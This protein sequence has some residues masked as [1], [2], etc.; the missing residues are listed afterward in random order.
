MANEI[1][2]KLDTAAA[3]TQTLAS[4]PTG[5]AVQTTMITNTNQRPGALIYYRLRS[6]GTGP[7]AGSVYELFLLRSDGTVSDDNAGASD[8]AITIENAPLLGT[9]ILTNTANKYF[10]GVFDTAPLGPLGSSWGIAVRNSSGQTM[11]ATE[12]DHVKRYTVYVPE[13]Q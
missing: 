10:Y 12:S 8:A 11:H 3:F 7:T 1:R 4:L 9:M 2:T 6:G 13:V 5:S